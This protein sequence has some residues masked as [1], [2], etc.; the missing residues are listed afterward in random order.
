MHFGQLVLVK[1][2]AEVRIGSKIK[3]GEG[4]INGKHSVVLTIQKQ[5]NA[6]TIDLT[7]AIDRELKEMERSLPEGVKLEKDLFKQSHFREK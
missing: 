1:D 2:V 5:P 7:A 6:S 4:S 3:R